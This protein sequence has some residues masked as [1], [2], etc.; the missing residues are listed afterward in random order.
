MSIPLLY[1]NQKE[2]GELKMINL[3]MIVFIITSVMIIVSRG[4]NAYMNSD[5]T[6]IYT[7]PAILKS[8]FSSL[9]IIGIAYLVFM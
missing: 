8:L 5:Y 7:I 6:F 4:I 1:Y 3:R 2:K 9:V